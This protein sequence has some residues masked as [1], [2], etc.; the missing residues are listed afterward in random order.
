[1]P[2]VRVLAD[3]IV[4]FT[5]YNIGLR[6]MIYPLHY[7]KNIEKNRLSGKNCIG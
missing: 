2:I 5:G 7:F 6:L 3:A 4:S 1:M